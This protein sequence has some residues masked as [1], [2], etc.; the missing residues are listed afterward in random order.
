M[1]TRDWTPGDLFALSGGYWQSFTLHAAVKLGL[2]SRCGREP[3][4][5]ERIAERLGAEPRALGML[6]RALA[7]MGLV[8]KTG[9]GFANTPFSEVFLSRDS[10]RYVG[11][12][13][14]HHHFLVDAWS[15]L[16]RAVMTGKPTRMLN[17]DTLQAEL[18]SF[19]MGMFNLAMSLA[20][21]VAEEVDLAGQGSLLDLGGGP[22]TYAIHFCMKNPELRAT[23]FDLPTARPI[24]EKTIERFGLKDRIAFVEGD[25]LRDP[26]PEGFDV[27][28]MSHVLHGEGPA[29]C[30]RLIERAVACLRPGGRILL[31]DFFLNDTLDGPIFPALFSLNMLV[32]TP[33]GQAYAEREVREMLRQAGIGDVRRLSFRGPSDSGILSGVR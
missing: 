9:E 33:G 29:A 10:E 5:E 6:L 28:W 7:A 2:F 8:H 25:F 17:E 1:N 16:D 24:A 19:L 22:G 30:R 13:I 27:V 32:N 12:I 23:V 20:P 18:E 26:L 14:L 4:S 15:R 31:H 21:R 11:H 3:L